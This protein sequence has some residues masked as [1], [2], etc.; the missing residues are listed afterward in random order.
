MTNKFSA[1]AQETMERFF[2]PHGTW[3]GSLSTKKH[4]TDEF[5]RVHRDGYWRGVVHG[6]AAIAVLSGAILLWVAL[7]GR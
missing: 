6:A 1:E 3:G 4:L 7:T 2:G 5:E